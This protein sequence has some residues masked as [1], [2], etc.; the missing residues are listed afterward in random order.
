MAYKINDNTLHILA[1]EGDNVGLALRL[2]AEAVVNESTPNTP[3]KT[4]PLRANVRKRVL[5]KT[6]TIKWGQEYAA[7]QEVGHHTVHTT[8]V[9]NIDGRYVT[10]TPGVYKYRNY[11]TPGTGPHFAE[12]AVKAVARRHRRYFRLANLVG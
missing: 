2:M 11:T 7:A 4:G 9:V 8:R 12:R 5:G 10:L 6:A 3:L 1:R